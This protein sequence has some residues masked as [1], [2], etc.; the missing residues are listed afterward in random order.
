MLFFLTL[1]PLKIIDMTVNQILRRKETMFIRNF[2]YY[3]IRSIKVMGEKTGA[4]LL[5]KIIY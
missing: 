5:L 3:G 1:D 2:N 4:V